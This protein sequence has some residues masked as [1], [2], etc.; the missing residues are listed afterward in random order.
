MRDA[1]PTLTGL[2][3]RA[4]GGHATRDTLRVRSITEAMRATAIQIR[5]TT[6]TFTD[7][8][9][10]DLT[11]ARGA[12]SVG[13]ALHAHA[14]RS[15]QIVGRTISS[16]RTGFAAPA[17][18]RVADLTALTIVGR[19]A[20]DAHAPWATNRGISGTVGGGHARAARP[21]KKPRSARTTGRSQPKGRK[22]RE[23]CALLPG[24][25]HWH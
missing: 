24:P 5:A 1:V 6:D 16:G 23:G 19:N 20:L 14:A 25:A 13:G 2:A 4:V 21:C 7:G 17:A 9:V 11:V 15:T 10:A 22:Q 3:R 8:R 12:I 18:E